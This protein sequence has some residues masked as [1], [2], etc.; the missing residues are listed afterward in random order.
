[1]KTGSIFPNKQPWISKSL[2]HVLRQKQL[3]C[4]EGEK[5][6]IEAQKLVEREIKQL[7]SGVK[8]KQRM[9]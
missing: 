6:K 4:Y 8:V 1:M 7:K 3:S 9:S 2:Q 5:N